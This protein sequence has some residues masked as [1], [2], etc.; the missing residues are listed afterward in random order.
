VDE[1]EVGGV[2]VRREVFA[3]VLNVVAKNSGSHG[4][5]GAGGR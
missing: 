2:D 5:C 1:R 4:F 3:E